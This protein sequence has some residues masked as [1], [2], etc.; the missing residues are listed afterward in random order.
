MGEAP[1]HSYIFEPGP[2]FLRRRK[3]RKRLGESTVW[4]TIILEAEI[5]KHSKYIGGEEIELNRYLVIPF[6]FKDVLQKENLRFSHTHSLRIFCIICN[7]GVRIIHLCVGSIAKFTLAGPNGVREREF[8]QQVAMRRREKCMILTSCQGP[9]RGG[10]GGGTALPN[11]NKERRKQNLLPGGG[12]RAGWC[13]EDIFCGFP[14][15][16]KLH[17]YCTYNIFGMKM[18]NF[19]KAFLFAILP[20][21]IFSPKAGEVSLFALM[22]FTSCHSTRCQKQQLHIR[23]EQLIPQGL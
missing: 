3:V 5:K 2:S 14:K 8:R 19:S 16:A 11:K 9:P 12:E 4:V 15:R 23:S 7:C 10:R 17:V 18:N 20:F 1:F 6:S 22:F 21:L 13:G